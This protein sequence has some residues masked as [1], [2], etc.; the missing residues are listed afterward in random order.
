LLEAGGHQIVRA[1]RRQGFDVRKSASLQ[2]FPA[3][4]AIVHLAALAFVPDSYERPAEF[5]ETNVTGTLN[6]LEVARLHK[7]RMIYVSSYVYGHPQYLPIDERHPAQA[8][9]PYAQTKLMAEELCHAW[10]RDFQVPSII[11][12]PFNIFGPGQPHHF[13]L[14]KIILQHLSGTEVSVFDARPRRD[15]VHVRDVANAIVQALPVKADYVETINIGAGAS[16]SISDVC[17][18]VSAITGSPVRLKDERQHRPNEI[19]DTVCDNSKAQA[20][21][22]WKPQMSFKEGLKDLI[23]YLAAHA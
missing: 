5:F 2:A 22:G 1:G 20:V 7:A 23:D 3:I 4:D 12:R 17:D 16:Y 18:L 21:L 8:F 6:M 15:Y 13:L 10:Q 9:N 11:L 14:P 19:M